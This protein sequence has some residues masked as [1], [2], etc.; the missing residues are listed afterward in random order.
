M[1]YLNPPPPAPPP[2]PPPPPSGE[3]GED[4]K[5]RHRRPPSRLP[6]EG[7]E[8]AGARR[9]RATRGQAIG[10]AGADRREA[11][12]TRAV[13]YSRC[14]ATSI[15]ACDER[16]GDGVGGETDLRHPETV[17]ARGRGPARESADGGLSPRP[18]REVYALAGPRLDWPAPVRDGGGE[19]LSAGQREAAR[20]SGVAD[21][22]HTLRHVYRCR[23]DSTTSGSTCRWWTTAGHNTCG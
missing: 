17:H 23:R 18:S 6:Q 14:D 16:V 8:D 12:S 9:Q 20:R 1:V 22:R 7:A 2:P 3:D 11:E 4:R 21:A 5:T 19:D 15:T 13:G 10:G